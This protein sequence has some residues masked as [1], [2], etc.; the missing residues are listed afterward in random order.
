[1][2]DLTPIIDNLHIVDKGG[3][4]HRFGDVMA[5]PQRDMLRRVNDDLTIGNPIRYVVLKARQIGM[6][7]M[8]E[9]IQFALAMAKQNFRGMVIAHENDSSRHLLQ[10]T[11]YY[12]ETFWAKDAYPPRHIAQNHLAWHHINSQIHVATA[13]NMKAGR[14]QTLQFLHASEVAF[15][16]NAETLM[17]GLQ[18]TV[19]R[20]PGT[21][22]FLETTANGVGGYF[23][24][25]WQSATTGTGGYIPLFY[26]WWAH[27]EYH[28]HAIGLGSLASGTFVPADDQERFLIRFLKQSR[29]VCGQRYPP[30]D[31]SEIKARLIWRRQILADE[32]QGDLNKLH[33]E[34]PSEVEEAFIATGS[35]VFNLD[36]LKKAYEPMR[37][38]VGRLVD[39]GPG[40]RFIHDPNGELEIYRH[41][42][43]SR[44]MGWYVIGGDGKKATESLAGRE[45]DYACAQVLNRKTWEQ[46][47]RWRGRL[48]QNKFGE[49][50]IRLGRFYNNALLAPETGIGGPGVAAHIIAKGYPH[51]Y[52]HRKA[53]KMPGFLDN[54][55]G[56]ISNAQTKPYAIGNLQ[57]AI[58]DAASPA[59]MARDIGIRIHDATTFHEM[60]HYVTLPNGQFGNAK[61]LSNFDDTV[62]ALAIALTVAKEEALLMQ[63]DPAYSAPRYHDFEYKSRLNPDQVD[64]FEEILGAYEV[65]EVA[66]LHQTPT[67]PKMDEESPGYDVPWMEDPSPD[68]YTEDMDIYDD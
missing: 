11:R 6:S 3:T 5:W 57:S 2:A 40:V 42:Q 1:M 66:S 46:V 30:M 22:I 47:A 24:D 62:M 27:P 15:W 48:D 65:P 52:V 31:A 12:Y 8:I 54:T 18:Q 49:M 32:C 56:W 55:M 28:A 16:D 60:K 41:P 19:G 45:G 64:R 39:D 4:D 26:P 25:A 33:Q 20:K 59:M 10:M 38:D 14:S 43:D 44:D 7:T 61:G 29:E 63:E 68:I 50:M 21:A 9:A 17:T 35:N 51:L 36:T 53:T 67:G 23:Y 58:H 13:K 34:Y 37:G